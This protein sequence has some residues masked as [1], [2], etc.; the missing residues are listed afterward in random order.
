MVPVYFQLRCRETRNLKKG[1]RIPPDLA[2]FWKIA[3]NAWKF[4]LVLGKI[5]RNREKVDFFWS[6]QTGVGP[7]Q[8]CL[9]VIYE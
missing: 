8:V 4:P 7:L 2:K 6:S 5:E 1:A 9:G 3:Q